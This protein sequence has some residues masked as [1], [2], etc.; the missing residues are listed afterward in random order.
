MKPWPVHVVFAIILVGSLAA[1]E[2]TTDVL[3]D[4]TNLEPT[5]IRVARS[6]GLVF[7]EY[8]TIAD[9][10]VR[11]LAFEASACSRPLLVVLLSVTFDQELVVR[12]AGS[13]RQPNSKLRYVYID[14]IWDQPQRLTVFVKRMKY[15]AL[16]VFGLTQ[17]APHRWVLLIE[18][19]PQCQ[20]SDDIDW[21][22]VWN[23]DQLRATEVGEEA[24]RR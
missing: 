13:A 9:T 15:T 19:P 6:Q 5:V 23:A 3:V 10:D 11:A 12:L 7:R 20:I 21:R 2:R 22:D 1:K 8:T 4:G 16:A 14:G 24:T 17:Y 18:S